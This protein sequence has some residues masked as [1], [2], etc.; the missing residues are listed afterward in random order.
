V[1]KP[2]G[3]YLVTA[4]LPYANGKI[5]LGH[6]AGAYIPSDIY[7][8]YLRS[9]HEDVLFICG[10]D[11]HGVPIT[12]TAEQEGTTPQA[13]VDRYHALNKTAFERVG[14]SFDNYARTSMPLHHETATEFFMKIYGAG[15]LKKKQ[16]KQ[17]Y[18]EKAKMFLPDR[19]VE[20]T[21]PTCGNP[22]ARGDQ[23]ERCGT[24]LNP[25]ELIKPKSKITGE[26][27]SVRETAHLYFPFGAYQEKI[28]RYIREADSRDGWKSNVAR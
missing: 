17:L 7:V 1:N 10:S 18:D 14:M 16:E 13:V 27:P 8:R 4:A 24:Y 22:E 11:E 21:C 25:L 26:T 6:L 3:P 19:Y 5:H 23:C 12:I 9:R 2:S 28:E 20:G 15:I